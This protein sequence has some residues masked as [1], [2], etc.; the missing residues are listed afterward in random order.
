MTS[1]AIESTAVSNE[2]EFVVIRLGNESYAI[3]ITSVREIIRMQRITEIPL[4]ANDLVG[5][6]K[7]RDLLIPVAELR[8]TLGLHDE[9][10]SAETRI[11]VVD[12]QSDTIG[13]VVDEVTAVITTSQDSLEPLASPS[14][15][16]SIE[17]TRH[18]CSASSIVMTNSSSWWTSKRSSAALPAGTPG[19]RRPPTIRA[20][21][22]SPGH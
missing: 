17:A 13:L 7:L 2:Q 4:T 14:R 19:S 15:A 10:T 16:P 5:V 3:A 6:T 1:S 18:S 20:R 22:R 11:V 21:S 9:E 12:P 8:P